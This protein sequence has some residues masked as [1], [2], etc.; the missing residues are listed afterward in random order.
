MVRRRWGSPA[1][2]GRAPGWKPLRLPLGPV[3][4]SP[5]DPEGRDGAIVAQEGSREAAG[6][7]PAGEAS[8]GRPRRGGDA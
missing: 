5:P 8:R 3:L 4:S 2:R 1:G 6:E 7:P